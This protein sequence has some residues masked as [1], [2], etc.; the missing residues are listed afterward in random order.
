M[1][2]DCSVMV[3]SSDATNPITRLEIDDETQKAVCQSFSEAVAELVNEKEKIKFDGC[4]KPEQDEFSV[5][6]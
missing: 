2:E 6:G 5:F 1:F 4:Y 3:M